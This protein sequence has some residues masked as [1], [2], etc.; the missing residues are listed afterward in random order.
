[1][2]HVQLKLINKKVT[3]EILNKM[4]YYYVISVTNY[5]INTYSQICIKR[6]PLEHIKSDLV[7]QVTP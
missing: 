6:S 7:R 3:N 5:E 2:I 1:M 4:Y